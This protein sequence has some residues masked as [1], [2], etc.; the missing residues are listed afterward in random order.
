MDEERISVVGDA[1]VW[2]EVQTGFDGQ[3]VYEKGLK[4]R[5][6]RVLAFLADIDPERRSFRGLRERRRSFFEESLRSDLVVAEGVA[7]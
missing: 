5:L 4:K 6:K 2:G 1:R 3:G 7:W